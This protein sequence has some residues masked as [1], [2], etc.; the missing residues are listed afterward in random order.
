MSAWLTGYF[1][2]FT[3]DI[4]AQPSDLNLAV[5]LFFITFV[6]FQPPSA[7]LGRWIGPKHWIPFMTVCAFCH[8]RLR[9]AWRPQCLDIRMLMIYR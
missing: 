4:G 5:S 9:M 1:T 2:G 6:L 8:T 3:R 7:A